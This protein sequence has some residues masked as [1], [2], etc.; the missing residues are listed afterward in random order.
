MR[1]VDKNFIFKQFVVKNCPAGDAQKLLTKNKFCVTWL[2]MTGKNK[3]K[4]RNCT[5][6]LLKRL[7][8]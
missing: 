4:R 5:D 8:V 7:D 3:R 1:V 6:K 2:R